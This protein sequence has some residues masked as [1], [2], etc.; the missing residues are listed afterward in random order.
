MASGAAPSPSHLVER[1]PSPPREHDDAADA[2]E[3]LQ[4]ED[5]ALAEAIVRDEQ[6]TH[7]ASNPLVEEGAEKVNRGLTRANT[8]NGSRKINFNKFCAKPFHKGKSRKELR[9]IFDRLDASKDGVL[10]FEEFEQY[11]FGQTSAKKKERAHKK[12]GVGPLKLIFGIGPEDDVTGMPSSSL[13]YP[14][15]WFGLAW[16]GLNV[17]F[18]AYI[19][20]ATPP[21]IAFYWLDDACIESPTLWF[22]FALDLFFL[23]DIIMNFNIGYIQ[24]GLYVDNRW[25][26][27]RHYFRGYF[28]FDCVTSFPVSFFEVMALADCAEEQG[29]NENQRSLRFVR[30]IKPLRLFKLARIFK[31][32]KG[33]IFVDTFMDFFNISPKHE[34]TLFVTLKFLMTLHM[35]TCAWWLWKVSAPACSCEEVAAFFGTMY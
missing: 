25:E 12:A 6:P 33:G 13:I 8:D 5:E 3:R 26:V 30:A 32:A 21:M 34:K 7:D 35:V 24:M 9:A 11:R 10:D 17:V 22:D 16:I 15:S 18:L 1:L 4:S 23:V 19:A 27:A 28:V 31:L 29:G 2:F 20:V 14:L